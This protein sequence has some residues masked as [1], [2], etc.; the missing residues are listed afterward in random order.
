MALLRRVDLYL[1]N[2]RTPG[3]VLLTS[4]TDGSAP[5]VPA[6]I[7]DDKFLLRLRFCDL[8][9]A[10]GGKATPTALEDDNVIVLAGKK[11]RGTGARLFEAANFV[12]VTGAGGD[13]YYQTVLKLNTVPMGAAWGTG[14]SQMT[15][16]VDVE[17]QAPASDG[18]DEPDKLTYQ[19]PVTIVRQ[20]YDGDDSVAEEDVPSYPAAEL[21]VMKAPVNGGYRFK[22]DG[23]G[24]LIFQLK[25]G[26]TGKFHAV[27]V[28]GEE[29]AEALTIGPGE[30]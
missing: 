9:E 15:V 13:V 4:L 30:V 3:N 23:A 21:L 2:A 18:G 11:T 26:T 14:E 27:F 16:Y 24:G 12:K 5:A 6:W 10:V 19:F 1:N 20:S 28:D 29:G 7:E 25:N 17:I 8:A 22:S